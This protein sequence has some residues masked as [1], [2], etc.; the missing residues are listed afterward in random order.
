MDRY[1]HDNWGDSVTP[2]MTGSL[3]QKR[4]PNQHKFSLKDWESRICGRDRSISTA[5]FKIR[6][7]IYS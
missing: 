2:G 4:H 5:Q 3:Y 7:I 1:R 6:G